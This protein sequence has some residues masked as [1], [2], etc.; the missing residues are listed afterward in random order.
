MIAM[1]D[2]K[3]Q[4]AALDKEITSGIHSVLASGQFLFGPQV[5]AFE[6]EAADYLGSRHAI[7][8]A[9]GTDALMLSL[10]ALD[11]GPGDEVITTPFSFFATVE[12]ILLTGATPVFVDIHPRSFN[13]N[14]ALVEQA[15]TEA[16]KA[17]LPVHLFG[18]PADMELLRSIAIHHELYLVEDCAQSFGASC[19]AGVTGTLGNTGCFSFFPSKNLGACGDGGLITTQDDQ[20]AARLR[21]LCNHGSHKRHCHEMTGYNSRLDE[22]QAVVLRAKLRRIDRYNEARRHWARYYTQSLAD[23]SSLI[24]PR[25][26]QYSC[27]VFNQYTLLLSQRDYVYEALQEQQIGCAIHYPIPLYR[28][29]ALEPLFPDLCL[30]VVEEVSAHCLSLPMHPELTQQQADE[31]IL[32]LR[33][34]LAQIG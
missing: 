24:T 32:T 14:P 23:M 9:S 11:I 28:Q 30:P 15:I 13:L 27:H 6:E 16:T 31:V 5:A 3:T 21:S 19:T 12:A 20:L 25:Q 4:N 2:L 7:S 34:T 33:Q 29:P 1:V 17:I 18:Q 8:C 10:R 22:F 26:D